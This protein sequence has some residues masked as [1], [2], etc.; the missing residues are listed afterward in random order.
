M[1]WAEETGQIKSGVG[2]FLERRAHEKQ[3]YC[4]REQF[5]TR[6]DKAVRAQ[7][8]RGRIAMRGLRIPK[9]A[10]WRADFESELLRFPAGVHDDQVDA[11]GLVGQLLDQM[12]AGVKPKQNV[13]PARDRWDRKRDFDDGEDYDWKAV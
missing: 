13:A 6:G 3:A 1:A 11:L 8:I 4:V 12:L 5:P 9:D 2:P 7:S 10:P